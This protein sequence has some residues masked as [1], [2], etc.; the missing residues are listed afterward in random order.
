MEK[1]NGC[2]YDKNGWKYISIY[3]SP[4]ERGYAY[5]FF[6]AKDFKKVQ[7]MLNYYCFEDIG[8][9][10]EF[11]VEAGKNHFKNKIK[12]EF[13]EFYEEM[14][15]ITEGINAGGTETNIDE[16]ITWNNYFTIVDS[17]YGSEGNGPKREGGSFLKKFTDRCS[18]FMAVGSYTKDGKIVVAHN[19]FTNFIDGQYWNYI[20][21]IK[22]TKGN[23]FI[24]N[25]HLVGYG[26]ELIIL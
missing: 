16:I 12:K 4:K 14:E 26:V 19:S 5:G 11:F 15:G 20:V 23:R 3:G 9:H 21:D 2:S 13:P 1:I 18:A 24:S 22:P 10:W 25:Q 17:W 6:S 8:K 7:E